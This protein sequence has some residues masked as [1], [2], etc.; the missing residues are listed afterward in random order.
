MV[1]YD[2]QFCFVINARFLIS[3]A[4]Y[5]ALRDVEGMSQGPSTGPAETTKLMRHRLN[6][7]GAPKAKPQGKALERSQTMKTKGFAINLTIRPNHH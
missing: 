2:Q 6:P 3:S 7:R 1:G 5:P 4:A